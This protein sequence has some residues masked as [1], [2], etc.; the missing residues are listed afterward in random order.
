MS[1]LPPEFVEL[2]TKKRELESKIQQA[3]TDFE[4][5]YKGQIGISNIDLIKLKCVSGPSSSV[6]QVSLEIS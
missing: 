4:L 6:V 2:M 3:V 1:L 5:Y